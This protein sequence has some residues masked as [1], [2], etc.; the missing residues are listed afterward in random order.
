MRNLCHCPFLNPES[1]FKKFPLPLTATQIE[2]NS[3]TKTA[4]RHI[5]V[6]YFQF[7]L[8]TRR[9]VR[10]TFNGLANANKPIFT[11]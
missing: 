7:W 2:E 6:Y 5:Y 8:E 3:G 9:L 1:G 10:I 11:I 4:G